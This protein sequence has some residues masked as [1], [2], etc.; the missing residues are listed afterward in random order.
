MSGGHAAKCLG[1][2]A[3]LAVK[4][5]TEVV[6]KSAPRRCVPGGTLQ[7][8]WTAPLRPLVMVSARQA[9]FKVPERP[10]QLFFL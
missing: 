5:Q 2:P 9:P 10:P 7:S 1:C 6:A 4:Q 8:V 3:A